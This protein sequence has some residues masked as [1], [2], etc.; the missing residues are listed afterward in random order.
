MK[1]ILIVLLL[2]VSVVLGALMYRQAN[3]TTKNRAELQSVQGDLAKAQSELKASQEAIDRAESVQRNS[4]ALQATLAQT[5]QFAK[6]KEQQAQDLQEKLTSSKTNS[7]NPMAGMAKMFKDPGMRDMIKNSQKAVMGPMI[8]KQYGAL[9]KQLNLTEEQSAELKKT[10]TDKMLAGAD[11][12]MSL[13]DDSLDATARAELTKKVQSDQLA[14]DAQIKEMLGDNYPEYQNYEKSVPD[15]MVASQFSDQLSGDL[16]MS[17]GQQSQLVQA[18][19]DARTGYKWTTDFSDQTKMG[20]GDFATMFTE[21]KLNQFTKE[22]ELFDQQFLGR[23][24]GILNP[25]Q[26]TQFEAFQKSQRDMQ[27][28]GL[29]MAASMF[30]PKN[31]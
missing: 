24:Q 17:D 8:D 12:G 2:A 30:G 4:K 19:T 14:Y 26:L 15:R 25:Q 3:Q 21:D 16:A 23:A 6:E 13:M 1:N 7:S 22:K 28:M 29:R 31:P 27:L 10:L 18:M 20:S 11:V 9:M 5:S